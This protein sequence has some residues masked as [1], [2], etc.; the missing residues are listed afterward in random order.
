VDLA[1]LAAV[2]VAWVPLALVFR[3]RQH[4]LDECREEMEGIIIRQER[5]EQAQRETAAQVAKAARDSVLAS[6]VA[7]TAIFRSQAAEENVNTIKKAILSATTEEE[8]PF[9]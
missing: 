6:T 7:H 4:Q 9:H 8:E 2:L 5:L 1:T 3:Y